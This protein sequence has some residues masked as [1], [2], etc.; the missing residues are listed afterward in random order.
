VSEE[1]DVRDGEASGAPDAAKD[2]EAADSAT[3]SDSDEEVERVAQRAR[4]V[5]VKGQRKARGSKSKKGKRPPSKAPASESALARRFEFDL[6][7]DRAAARLRL[8]G[9]CIVTPAGAWLATTPLEPVGWFFVL[10]AFAVG[11]G[12]TLSFVRS[13]RRKPAQWFLDLS[14]AGLEVAYGSDPEVTP[15]NDL[16]KVEVDEDQLVV[17]VTLVSSEEEEIF[18][19][20]PPVWQGVSLHELGDA[21]EAARA[22]WAD[23]EV[24]RTRETSGEEQE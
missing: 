23:P 12:W 1:D 5:G 19:A 8:V 22:A 14:P 18:Y 24:A 3:D 20:I 7:A 17:K 16:T 13:L 2:A 15:W 21:I 10:L 11:L 6:A 4:H 9:A